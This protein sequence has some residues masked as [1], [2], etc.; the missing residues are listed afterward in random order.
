MAKILKILTLPH[1]EAKLRQISRDIDPLELTQPKF[2]ALLV[3]MARTMVAKDGIGLAAPQIG[4]TIRLVVINFKDKPIWMIN[5]EIIK[6]ST[7]KFADQEGC[8]SIP[9]YYAKVKRHKSL[10]CKFLDHEGKTVLVEATGLLARA[11]QHEI[12]HL[13]GILFIDRMEKPNAKD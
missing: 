3:N 8:L 1:Q 5:P 2:K 12:D 6:K 13:D 10:T 9:G 4:E 11:I 7:T